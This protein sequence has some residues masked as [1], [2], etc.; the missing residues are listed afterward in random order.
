MFRLALAGTLAMV[1]VMGGCPG[2]GQEAVPFAAGTYSGTLECTSVEI[3]GSNEVFDFDA[4]IEVSAGGV[5][6]VYGDE[7]I[8][9]ETYEFT[10]GFTRT[11]TVDDLIIDGDVVEVRL[12][13]DVDDEGEITTFEESVLLEQPDA[14]S[15]NVD[16]L[17]VEQFPEGE[18]RE[19]CIGTLTRE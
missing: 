19:N 7:I 13:G 6:T 10:N 18:Y 1:L 15:L 12:S 5:L 3:D 16:D 14:N 11:T 2:T 8:V 17:W 4:V 9:G